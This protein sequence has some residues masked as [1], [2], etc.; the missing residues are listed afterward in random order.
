MTPSV[1]CLSVR[2]VSPY[3]HG[4]GEDREPEWP[5]SPL[6]LFQALVAAAAARW[7]ER[8]AIRHAAPALDWLSAQPPPTIVACPGAASAAPYRQ[9]VPSNVGDLVARAWVGSRAADMASFRTEKD[10]WPVQLSDDCSVHH[11]YSLASAAHEPHLETLVATARALTHLG[12]GVDVVVGDAEVIRPDATDALA[13]E[14]WRPSPDGTGHPLRVPC[15][16]TLSALG[17]RH[18]AFLNR[19]SSGSFAPV[20]PLTTF[21]TVGYRRDTDPAPRAVT[22]FELRTSELDRPAT[23][24]DPCTETAAVAGMVR[25]AVA[26]LASATAPFGWGPEEVGAMVQGH[27]PAGAARPAGGTADDRFSFLPLA[28]VSRGPAVGGINRVLVVAPPSRPA[29]ARWARLLSGE[30]L[31]ALPG[32][33]PSAL[34][35]LDPPAA[36]RSVAR[37]LLPARTWSTVTPVLRSGYDDRDP[38]K[39]LRLLRRAFVQAG[40]P[41]GLVQGAEIEWRAVG[42]LR[43]VSHACRYR[44]PQGLAR[45]A[46]VHVRV[47]WPTAVS[48]PIAVGAGRYRG[49][50]VFVAE[51][52]S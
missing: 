22:A 16:G 24:Y 21:D 32:T 18:A 35:I 3:F 17:G 26:E 39:A 34:T 49:F 41:P 30:R 14:W 52:V 42:Y 11:L 46:R 28:E 45:N 12:R 43:G 44:P 15:P 37:Y 31:A 1:L 50:G 10:L 36:D 2:F 25:H 29:A 9:Y 5:P 7:G 4:R 48:G 51:E 27:A 38:G 19:L 33:R 8:V 40:F 23:V 6:R 20:S 13:G 47:T